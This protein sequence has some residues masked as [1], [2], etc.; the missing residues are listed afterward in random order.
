MKLLRRP[1]SA[2]DRI[3]D[4]FCVI[5]YMEFLS[6]SRRRSSSQNVPQWRWARRNV[7]RS[8]ATSHPTHRVNFRR[9]QRSNT[10]FRSVL[11]EFYHDICIFFDGLAICETM[12]YTARK[13]YLTGPVL[14]LHNN[15]DAVRHAMLS[16]TFQRGRSGGAWKY[17]V[18]HLETLYTRLKS[19]FWSRF[20][21]EGYA[22]ARS[23]YFSTTTRSLSFHVFLNLVIPVRSKALIFTRK[24]DPEDSG[25]SSKMASS[26]VPMAVF[27][28]LACFIFVKL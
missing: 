11:G 1:I 28:F 18:V 26:P 8:Q 20:I 15:V 19:F 12:L 5:S 10:K 22:F 23:R 6:L 14:Q 17:I 24:R 21:N 4:R 13:I 27:F 2:S 25:R 9:L 7:C 16:C 3:P